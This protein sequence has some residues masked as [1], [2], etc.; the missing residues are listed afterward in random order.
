MLMHRTALSS[1]D[2]I[3][4]IAGGLPK[5]GGITSLGPLFPHIVK[6]Y[7][8]GEERRRQ[9]RSGGGYRYRNVGAGGGPCRRRC[10]NGRR[11]LP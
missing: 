6:A 8:I 2:R 3:Y 10:S 1:Y 9:R 5:E 4:W 7:L 11:V